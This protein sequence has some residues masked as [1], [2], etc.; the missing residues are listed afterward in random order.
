MMEEYVEFEF[1]SVWCLE[2]DLATCS[3]WLLGVLCIFGRRI[4]NLCFMGIW[5]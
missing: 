3:M 4:S 5:R 1:S 2:L